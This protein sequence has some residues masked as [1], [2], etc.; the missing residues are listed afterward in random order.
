M[1]LTREQILSMGAG[2]D[3]D[4]L[5]DQNVFGEIVS[6]WSIH[7]LSDIESMTPDELSKGLGTTWR[8]CTF[9]M[10]TLLPDKDGDMPVLEWCD[11]EGEWFGVS[12]YSTD[13]DDAMQVLQSFE[14]NWNIVRDMG[15]DGNNYETEGDKLYHVIYA[16]PGMPMYGVKA[17]TLPLAIVRAALLATLEAQ[18]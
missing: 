15:K 5:V 17:E 4:A 1:E 12:H 10:E 8:P 11:D 16:S 2:R 14:Y 18:E 13:I 7:P 9:G 3:M 6:W